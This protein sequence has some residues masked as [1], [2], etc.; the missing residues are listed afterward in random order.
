MNFYTSVIKYGNNLLYRGYKNGVRHE[1]KIPFKPQLFVQ[2]PKAT[3]QYK[4]L[5]GTP[6][7]PMDFDSMRDA[8]EF[9]QKY[10]DIPNFPIYAQTNFVTQFLANKFPR[11]VEFDREM[12]NVCTIDIEVASDAGFPS[13]EEAAHPVISITVKNNQD[14]VY[15][16]FGLYDY[17]ESKTDMNVKYFLCKDEATLLTSF[18]GW[19]TANCPD[20]ITGWNTKLFDMP[21]LVRRIQGILGDDYKKLSPWKLIKEKMIPTL[22]GRE[23]IAYDVDGVVQLDYYDLFKKFTLNTY[24]QQ[25]SY[26]LDHIANVVL[27]E[28]KLS[29]EEYGSLHTLYKFDFQKFIDYNIKD[30]E[31][32]DRLEE[33]LGIITLVMTMAYSAKTNLT[34]ALGTTAIWDAIIYNELLEEGK[35]IPQRPPI[36]EINRKIAGGFVKEPAVGSHDWV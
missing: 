30:V 35:V 9:E 8:K 28:R 22:G 17:D 6:V 27:G 24:G 33:K 1:E 34:D 21:Y 26:K 19:W 11:G 32:V 20:I 15:Y 3:G 31:L 10:K 14:N 4:T 25:E 36:P 16:V 23:Q 18:L 2:S 13:P 29:Y 12:V 7:S 5:E